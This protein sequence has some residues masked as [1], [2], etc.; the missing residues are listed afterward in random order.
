[1]TIYFTEL[2]EEI[3]CTKDA[4]IA[5]MKESGLETLII[6]KVVRSIHK[7]FFGAIGLIQHA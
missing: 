1:M 7:G 4:I 5:D 3:A 6:S 2:N